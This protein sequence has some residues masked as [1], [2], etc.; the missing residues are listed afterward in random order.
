MGGGGSF[1]TC[2]SCMEALGGTCASIRGWCRLISNAKAAAYQDI[3]HRQLLEY[4]FMCARA[5][6]AL[7][8]ALAEA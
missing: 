3:V 6:A 8:E 5:A 7:H 1:H 2:S 4:S